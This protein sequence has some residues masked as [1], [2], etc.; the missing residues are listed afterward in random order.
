MTEAFDYS[1]TAVAAALSPRPDALPSTTALLTEGGDARIALDPATGRNKY[2]CTATPDGATADFS[3]STASSISPRGFA[4]ADA[5]R[6][7]LA[8]MDGRER[9]AATYGRELDR[10]RAELAGLCG[11][12]DMA[13][14]DIVFA[15]SGTDLHLLVSALVGG[16][17]DRPLVSIDVEAEE[18]G[19]GVPDALSGRHFSSHTA[20]GETVAPG[21]GVGAHA[22]FVAVPVRDENGALRATADIEV[23]LDALVLDAAM[24]G[25]RAL[26]TVTDVS[27][28]GLISPPLEV[29]LAL[30][31]R[32]PRTLEVLIDA[33][34]FR[35]APETLRAY[36]DHGF[37]VAVTGSKFLTG[38]T[39]SGALFVPEAVGERLNSRLLPP[40]LR[41]YSA[42]ADWPAAWVAGAGM[43]DSA[44]FGLL[45]RWEAAL[46]ELR[47][48]RALP[49]ADVK[50]FMDAFAAAIHARLVDD[51]AFVPL[52]G[53]RLNR[54]A[55]GAAG[56]WDRTASI[57][58]FLLRQ[59]GRRYLGLAETEA[60]YRALADRGA[61]LGQPVRC[62]LRD[63]APVSA[64]RLCNSA[65]LITEA[66]SD[67]GDPDAVISRALGVLDAIAAVVSA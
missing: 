55:I 27:K 42:R 38:P 46:A 23:E 6:G 56:A 32:F 13:G 40:G 1:A 35:L 18:T 64:L 50:A 30:V 45:L 51:P 43:T 4:A 9:R 49:A 33:C 59:P 3:S 65:R 47:A 16:A 52:P 5:L 20:L 62:G 15:A 14:L 17:P 41:A 7:R 37:M 29:V 44:N 63:G 19:S 31:R 24:S 36:L 11:L 66:L 26:L 34:Q 2:G 60:V 57:F 28:T 21:A 25:Q 54:A 53:R 58:P 12:G 10:L 61:R 8:A 67:G 39:F 22:A 48:F